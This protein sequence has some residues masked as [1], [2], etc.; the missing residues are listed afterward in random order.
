MQGLG[1]AYL[2]ILRWCLHHRWVVLVTVLG[3]MASL[4]LLVKLT[5]FNF[6]PQ[7]DSSEFEIAFQAPEGSTLQRRYN[8]HRRGGGTAT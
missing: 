3:C 4:G 6:M 5:S 2:G 1:G 7:D 8:A